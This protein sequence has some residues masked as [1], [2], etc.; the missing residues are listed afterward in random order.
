MKFLFGAAVA[1]AVMISG[2]AEAGFRACNKSNETI[3]VAIG[4]KKNNQWEA[5]GWWEIKRGDCTQ[6]VNGPLQNRYYYVRA[7]G[8]DGNIWGGDHYFCTMQTRFVMVDQENCVSSTVDRE[9]FW[10]VDTGESRD[11]THTFN[12]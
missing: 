6:L 3:Y 7:E 5:E 12:P 8:T 10:Q 4:F 2:A 1:A 9:G 11:H